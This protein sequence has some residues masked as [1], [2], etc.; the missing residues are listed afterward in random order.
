MTNTEYRD[1]LLNRIIH[2]NTGP[3]RL[4]IEQ[5]LENENRDKIITLIL[6]E[7]GVHFN[8]I[9]REIE[10]SAGTLVW[11]LDILET[12]KVIQKQRIGQYLVYYP[13][14]VKNPI[15]KLDLKLRKSRTTLEILQ[16][17]ND[18]PGM[19]QNQIARRMDLNH[20]TVK[21]HIDKLIESELIMAKKKGRKNLFFPKKILE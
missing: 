18:H 4:T 21:Y 10:I 2:F 16:L 3:H 15:N 17:I 13:Y 5:V 9:L 7:P 6:E 19:Y 12:F 14:T 11:H 20:K 8:E 1:Y